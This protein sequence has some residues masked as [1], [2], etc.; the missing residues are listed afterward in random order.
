MQLNKLNVK[1][2]K[3]VPFNW[4][5]CDYHVQC[6]QTVIINFQ[7][8]FLLFVCLCVCLRVDC[9]FIWKKKI[10]CRVK[11]QLGFSSMISV[12][13]LWATIHCTHLCRSFISTSK[14]KKCFPMVSRSF[15]LSPPLSLS[16]FSLCIILH[17]RC[18]M[19]MRI[20]FYNRIYCVHNRNKRDLSA[21]TWSSSFFPH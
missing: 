13:K 2:K 1:W 11:L 19:L 15:P 5:I 17:T 8:H 6:I 21:A 7:N 14:Q 3:R 10:K 20:A 12:Y 18:L 16:L 4:N 9:I